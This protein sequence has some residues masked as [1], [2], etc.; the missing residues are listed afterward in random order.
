MCEDLVRQVP[1]SLCIRTKTLISGFLVKMP[2]VGTLAKSIGHLP[3]PFLK[4]D[5]FSVDQVC[6]VHVTSR[7]NLVCVCRGCFP[8]PHECRVS[9]FAHLTQLVGLCASTELES[10]T[11]DRLQAKMKCTQE[12]IKAMLEGEVPFA[13]VLA[14]YP[15]G[16]LANTFNSRRLLVGNPLVP[17]AARPL[18][19]F[20]SIPKASQQ[21]SAALV[22][23]R[24]RRHTTHPLPTNRKLILKKTKVT[25]ISKPTK[26]ANSAPARP[27]YVS[28][29]HHRLPRSSTRDR[30]DLPSYRK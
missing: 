8:L 15:E 9:P 6:G 25:A 13:K 10:R 24:R 21:P 30:C 7:V 11:M 22:R 26:T 28:E 5:S 3:V 12:K 14:F 1:T 20:L 29:P 4:D 18:A 17:H 23:R 2:I 27:C 19:T 16:V